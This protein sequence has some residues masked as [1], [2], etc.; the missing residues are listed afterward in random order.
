MEAEPPKADPAKRKRRWFQFSLRSL[1]IFTVIC[2]VSAGWLGKRIEQKRNE[3]EAA[4]AIVKLGGSVNYDYEKGTAATPN[5]P[6][7]LRKLFGENFFSDVE[8]VFFIGHSEIVGGSGGNVTDDGLVELKALPELK[9]LHLT[10]T[11]KITDRGLE[12][13]RGLTHLKYIAVGGTGVTDAG[14]SEL[15]EL[16]LLEHLFLGANK[17]TDGGLTSIKSLTQLRELSLD[18]DNVTD[19][20][21]IN[22]ESLARLEYLTLHGS[23]FTDAGL[24]HLKGLTRLKRLYLSS[25]SKFTDAGVADLQRALP[26][27]KI[28]R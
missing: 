9:M 4:E 5:G 7:W 10:L 21:L 28:S 6:A 27:C 16:T 23:H 14:L 15:K 13:I 22:L 11:P 20:G 17:I 2:A 12:N 19:A 26:N 8:D 3:R 25:H 24:Q 18:E 1:L